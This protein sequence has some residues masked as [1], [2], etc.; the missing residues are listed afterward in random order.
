[1]KSLSS[2]YLEVRTSVFHTHPA[3]ASSRATRASLIAP[4]AYAL[5]WLLTHV[6]SAAPSAL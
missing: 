4:F 2:V 3:T 1:M 5:R 6:P